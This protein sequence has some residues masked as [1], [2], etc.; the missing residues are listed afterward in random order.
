MLE[1]ERTSS[2][3][4]TSFSSLVHYILKH[5]ILI[6]GGNMNAT[7]KKKVRKKKNKLSLRNSSNKNREYI[8]DFTLE[9]WLTC[10]NSK[11]QKRK[12]NQWTYIYANNTKK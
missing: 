8:T 2:P 6:I 11:F 9:H 4:V 5:N 7:K 1:A 12:G 10:L 3:S